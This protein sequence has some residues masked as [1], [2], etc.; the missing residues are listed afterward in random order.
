MCV[1]RG[2]VYVDELIERSSNALVI[3]VVESRFPAAQGNCGPR[4]TWTRESGVDGCVGDNEK[5][6]VLHGWLLQRQHLGGGRKHLSPA[7]VT[8]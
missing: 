4:P 6:D 3:P 8:F 5:F 2:V 1:N 7:P